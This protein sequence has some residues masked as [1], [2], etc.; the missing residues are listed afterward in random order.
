LPRAALGKGFAEDLGGFAESLGPSAKQPAPV[1]TLS[2]TSPSL[3][4]PSPFYLPYHS[5]PM[6]F[7]II[8]RVLEKR[9]LNQ[10]KLKYMSKEK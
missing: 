1:V 6:N 4:P 2:N 8:I 7:R 10:S 9:S 5:L 3:S